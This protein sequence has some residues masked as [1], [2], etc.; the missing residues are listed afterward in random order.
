MA[1]TSQI[2]ELPHPRTGQF[3]AL[4]RRSVPFVVRQMQC[5]ARW[6]SLDGIRTMISHEA[7]ARRLDVA[8]TEEKTTFE[9]DARGHQS[10]SL[11]LTDF[12]DLA[13]AHASGGTHW[14]QRH[15]LE[16]YLCQVIGRSCQTH[17]LCVVQCPIISNE[18]EVLPLLPEL[19]TRLSIPEWLHGRQLSRVNLWLSCGATNT[20]THY[21]ANDNILLVTHGTKYVRLWPPGACSGAAVG[22]CSCVACSSSCVWRSG[23]LLLIMQ[24]HALLLSS[25]SD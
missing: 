11:R 14:L 7:A 5:G 3:A 18:P 13:Q 8:C 23:L 20:N 17:S 19:A 21:D 25:Q 10:V 2:R 12:L 9:G 1:C 24:L 15:G 6:C 4:A 22:A 16:F